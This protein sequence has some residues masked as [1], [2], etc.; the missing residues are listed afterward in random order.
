M[1]L[2]ILVVWCIVSSIY[3]FRRSRY[4]L[5]LLNLAFSLNVI[6]VKLFSLNHWVFLVASIGLVVSALLVLFDLIFVIFSKRDD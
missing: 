4:V 5:F 3:T 1:N 2:F 6:F